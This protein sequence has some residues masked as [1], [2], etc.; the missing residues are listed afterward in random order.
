MSVTHEDAICL[1]H[2]EYSETSQV[3][4]LLTR[5]VGLVRALAKG[6]RRPKTP[7]SGGVEL[8]TRGTAGLIIKPDVDLSLLTEWDLVET[9]S[10]LRTRLVPYH[11]ASYLAELTQ[12]ALRDRDPHPALFDGLV[13]S[14]RALCTDE[15]GAAEGSGRWSVLASFQW[16]LLEETGYRPHLEDAPDLDVV[17][18]SPERGE[19]VASDSVLNGEIWKVRRETLG[20]LRALEEGARVEVSPALERGAR[21]L[22]WYLRVVLGREPH[23]FPLVFGEAAPS[24]PGART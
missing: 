1:R 3:V 18:F 24:G 6:S 9:F 15:G 11:V 8:L 21:L 2:W 5:R 16:G 12:L 14:L 23:T 17:G 7:F 22:G 4:S 20:V 13:A 10:R 19:F